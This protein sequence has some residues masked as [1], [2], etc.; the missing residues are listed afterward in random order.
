VTREEATEAFSTRAVG[1]RLRSMFY[2]PL[3]SVTDFYIPFHFFRVSISS[4]GEQRQRLFGV[5]AVTGELNL[6]EFENLPEPEDVQYL[7]T[8]NC[9]ETLLDETRAQELLAA[10]IR[11]Q[12]RE[13]FFL[14]SGLAIT[15]DPVSGEICIPYWV[16]FQGSGLRARFTIMD[17]MRR[18]VESGQVRHLVREWLFSVASNI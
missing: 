12:F 5:D 13:L 11:R 8:R 14:N 2:G 7:E 4:R 15:A 10:K 17:A 3:H 1:A 6:Y 18:R 9:P 16:G